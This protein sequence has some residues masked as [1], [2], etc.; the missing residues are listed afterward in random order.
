MTVPVC[1]AWLPPEAASG[2]VGGNGTGQTVIGT[3]KPQGWRGGHTWPLLN[4]KCSLILWRLPEA[5]TPPQDTVEAT[6]ALLH[7]HMGS[8]DGAASFLQEGSVMDLMGVTTPG[9]IN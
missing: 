8:S 9:K 2:W 7:H 4:S 6:L 1:V 5:E 3:G